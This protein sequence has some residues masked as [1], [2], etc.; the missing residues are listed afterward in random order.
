[1]TGS[2]T[3]A[4]GSTSRSRSSRSR[5]SRPPGHGVSVGPLRG[6]RAGAGARRAARHAVR[7]APLRPAGCRAASTR[8]PTGRWA[9][10]CR[11]ASAIST[12]TS[13]AAGSTRRWRCSLA[14][15]GRAGERLLEHVDGQMRAAAHERRYERAEWLRRRARR[16]RVDPRPLEGVLEAT[17][18]RPRLLL[19]RAP[20]RR[21]RRRVLDRRR[22]ASATGGRSAM[23]ARLHE[24]T[25]DRARCAAARGAAS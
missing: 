16:L 7:A 14:A 20:D 21:D 3:S 11:R 17:H 8:R 25:R 2:C 9:A 15:D 6:R 12:R 24:R 1:M 18:A 22:P 4:A 19:A 13:T 10:A 23:R 5:P